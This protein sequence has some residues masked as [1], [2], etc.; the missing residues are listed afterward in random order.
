MVE[1]RLDRVTLRRLAARVW[2]RGDRWGRRSTRGIHM[3]QSAI[4]FSWG[5]SVSGREAMGLG[6]FSFALQYFGDL[7]Q[8]GQIEDL[9]VYLTDSGDVGVNAGH[10]IVEG[11]TAQINAVKE[12]ADYQV[13]VVKAAHVVTEFRITM[14]STGDQVPRKIEQLQT[15]RKELGI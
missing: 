3:A 14:S 9:R 7:K 13:L 6:V 1:S 15:A 8:K 11:S 2:A 12:R 4:I 5:A 10:M